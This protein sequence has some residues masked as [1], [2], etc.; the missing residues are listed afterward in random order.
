MLASAS[1]QDLTLDSV[2]PGLAAGPACTS[3]IELRNLGAKPMAVSVEG[4]AETGALV[5]LEGQD[6]RVVRLEAGERRSLS[7][8]AT[9]K[10]QTGWVK[11]S[12]PLAGVR[13]SPVVAVAATVE[14]TEND[15][16][17]TVSRPVAFAMRNPWL[18]TDL[19]GLPG[20]ELLI[21]NAGPRPALARACYSNGSLYS[22]PAEH[23]PGI[24]LQPVCS[25]VW[26]TQL[27]PYASARVALDRDDARHVSLHT[28]GEAIVLQLQRPLEG[29]TRLFT[30]D[31]TIHFG[32]EV[33]P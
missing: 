31:S 32:Q 16:L 18:D 29:S 4:H 17:R 7:F 14:C 19:A 30:V 12:E 22:V 6:G 26:E 5:A 8:P 24:G 2:V 21:V 13:A 23:G 9:D 20:A 10:M 3:R 11:V 25:A 15:L 28:W 27:A 33:H 1:A